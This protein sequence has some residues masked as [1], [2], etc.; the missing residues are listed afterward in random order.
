VSDDLDSRPRVELRLADGMVADALGAALRAAGTEV[1][2]AGAAADVVVVDRLTRARRGAASPAALLLL[3]P[4]DADAAARGFRLGAR[5]Y[6][7]TTCSADD[8]ATAVRRL[9]RGEVHVPDELAAELGRRAVDGGLRSEVD[10]LTERQ[11]QVVALLAAGVDRHQIAA[12]LGISVAT[13]RTH[14]RDAFARLGVH[15][16]LEAAALVRDHLA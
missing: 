8:L 12:D 2:G 16:T 11:R 5:G 1:V 10:Q 7:T 13:V 3:G 6:V 14:V 15:S 4:D 9:A